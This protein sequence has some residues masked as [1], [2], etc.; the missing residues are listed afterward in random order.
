M[1]YFLWD[2]TKGITNQS[3]SVCGVDVFYGQR[4]PEFEDTE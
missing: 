2:S 1:W 4:R 3:P